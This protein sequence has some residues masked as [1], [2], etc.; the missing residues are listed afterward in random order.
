MA[1]LKITYRRHRGIRRVTRRRLVAAGD[2]GIGPEGAPAGSGGEGGAAAGPR[3]QGCAAAGPG[4][5]GWC[6]ILAVGGD[7]CWLGGGARG[8]EEEGRRLEEARRKVEERSKGRSQ[9]ESEQG[10]VANHF[11]LM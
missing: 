10:L 9:V 7:A 2:V 8:G 5:G 3:G 6:G 11:D 4:G 1:R